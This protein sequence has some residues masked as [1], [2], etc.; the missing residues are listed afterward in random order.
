M[1][2]KK[3]NILHKI[4]L[5]CYLVLLSQNVFAVSCW[6]DILEPM[7]FGAYDPF[8]INTD[9]DSEGRIKIACDDNTRISYS[10]SL[11]TGSSGVY[12][13]RTMTL[14]GGSDTLNYNLHSASN[15]GKNNIW[16]D[17]TSGTKVIS[18]KGRCLDPT[19]CVHVVYGRV[20]R[21]QNY[22]KYGD[23]ID[24]IV[25]SVQY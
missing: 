13:A 5:L 18:K 21:N 9:V 8:A 4:L 10:I 24:T 12:S 2:T 23:Y 19:S 6:I 16:G 11:S 25:V 7:S 3:I 20:T 14:V 17:G 22:A 1:K 15:R